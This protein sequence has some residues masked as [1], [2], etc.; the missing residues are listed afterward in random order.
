MISH[1]H[2]QVLLRVCRESKPPLSG[3]ES[4]SWGARKLEKL[5][6]VSTEPAANFYPNEDATAPSGT[7]CPLKVSP[8]RCRTVPFPSGSCGPCLV[9]DNT[10]VASSASWDACHNES[11]LATTSMRCGSVQP[12]RQP[13][14]ARNLWT[15]LDTR[16]ER[17][18][19]TRWRA[20]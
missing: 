13:H 14:M 1:H 2:R 4:A 8:G 6:N 16:L 11:P 9:R 19:R 10:I 15:G 3:S 7:A 17:P 20:H 12:G 18:K 5:G